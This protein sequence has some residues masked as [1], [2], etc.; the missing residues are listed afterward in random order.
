MGDHILA[1]TDHHLLLSNR[2]HAFA[3]MGKFPEALEDAEKC[4]NIRRDWQ[5]VM[6]K[7]LSL[8][9]NASFFDREII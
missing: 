5:K 8:K 3:S 9:L 6:L 2:S 7:C 4:I 1:K